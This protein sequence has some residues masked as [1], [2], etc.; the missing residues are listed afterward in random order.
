MSHLRTII[1]QVIFKQFGHK[2]NEIHMK[3]AL[4]EIKPD[5]SHAYVLITNYLAPYLPSGGKLQ[6]IMHQL[7]FFMMAN[8]HFRRCGYTHFMINLVLLTTLHKLLAFKLD[9][10]PLYDMFC[11]KNDEMEILNFEDIQIK[12]W[13]VVTESKDIAFSSFL[14]STKLYHFMQDV[15]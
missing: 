13:Q 4:L 6:H 12:S 3:N 1:R 8:D 11:S 10:P 7:P 2:I 5:E 15:I 9:A 14:I